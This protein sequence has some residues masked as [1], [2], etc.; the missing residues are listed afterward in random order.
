MQ[1]PKLV[2]RG[3]CGSWQDEF[4]D[5]LL[6]LFWER[7]GAVMHQFGYGELPARQAA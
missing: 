1:R 4:P 2:R 5:D 3:Q 7:H 6:P